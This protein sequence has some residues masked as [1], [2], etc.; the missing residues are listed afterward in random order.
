VITLICNQK[1]GVGK[2][3]LLANIAVLL[4]QQGKDVL[5]VDADR[6]LSVS[7]WWAERKLTHP[8]LPKIA[9]VQQYGSIDDTL[10]DLNNRYEHVLVDVTGRDSEELRSALLVCDHVIVPFRPSQ[11][12]LNVIPNVIKIINQSKRINPK[13]I[14]K[15]C[16]SIA[17]TNVKVK[18][19]EQ[20]INAMNGC[21]DLPLLNTVIYDRKIYRDAMA[22]GAGVTEMN[23]KSDSDISAHK[24]MENL[25][26]E[27]FNDN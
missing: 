8:D 10:E 19:V 21:D 5:M 18:D 12:D 2:S 25:L 6:Q 15:S 9:C 7:E 17:P 11:V 13:L 14:A 4:S 1:G 24:E 20:I 27:I 26:G 16:I 22:E 23:G 3:T